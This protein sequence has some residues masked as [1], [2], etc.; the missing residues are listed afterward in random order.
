MKT[1]H[2]QR[3]LHNQR[4]HQ[5]WKRCQ[6]K[7]ITFYQGCATKYKSIRIINIYE[8]LTT[9]VDFR[10]SVRCEVAECQLRFANSSQSTSDIRPARTIT[11]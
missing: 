4:C 6:L 11:V 1:T 5:I 8:M 9:I 2:F 10:C 3:M 7:L